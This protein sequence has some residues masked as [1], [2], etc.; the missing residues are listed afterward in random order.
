MRYRHV[1]AMLADLALVHAVASATAVSA[2]DPRRSGLDDMSPATQAMQLDDSQNPAMLWVQDGKSL[3]SQRPATGGGKSC[4]DCH[5][6]ATVSQRGVAARYPALD[7][8]LN[9]PLTLNQRITECRR[10]YQPGDPPLA[11]ESQAL[12]G[13]EAYLAM[14]SRGQTLAPPADPRLDP[15]RELGRQWFTRRIGQLNLACTQCHDDR[16]GQHLGGSVI[17]QAHPT[18]YPEYRLEW[19]TLGSLQRRIRNCMSGVRAEPFAFG[20][21]EMTAI[22]LYLAQRAAGMRMEGAGVRP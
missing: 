21:I 15:Y 14:Q 4:A 8:A 2:D 7:D 16:A 6:D 12:L 22:E 20:S 1:I 9:R 13:L 17:P 5:G 18:A 19:Q 11:P 3:W 10:R